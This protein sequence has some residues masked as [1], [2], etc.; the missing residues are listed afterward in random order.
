VL[1]TYTAMLAFR[2]VL[3]ARGWVGG[4]WEE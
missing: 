4:F 2:E 1:P 3:R